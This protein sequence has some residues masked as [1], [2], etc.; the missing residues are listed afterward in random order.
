VRRFFAQGGLDAAGEE[1][2]LRS[3]ENVRASHSEE[4]AGILLVSSRDQVL[5]NDLRRI[6]RDPLTV[7]PWYLRA[8]ENPGRVAL[9]PKPIGR[10]V[11]GDPALSADDV[12]SVVKAVD[13][14]QG[15]PAGAILIDLKLKAVEGVFHGTS[16]G[17][18]GFFFITDR[19]GGIVYA[20]VNKVIYRIPAGWLQEGDGAGVRRVLGSRYQILSRDSIYTGWRTVGVFSINELLKEIDFLRFISILIAAVTMAIAVMVALFLAS[21]IARPVVELRSLM[22]RVEGGDLSV[23][24]TPERYDEVGQLGRSFNVMI[25]EIRNLIGQVYEEQRKKREAEL[26]ALH[27][28]IK[29]HF[30][31]NTLDTVKWMA[32]ERGADDVADMVEAITRIFR[33]GLSR[34]RE[35]ITLADEIEHVRN[36]LYIEKVRYEDKFDYRVEYDETLAQLYVIKLILQPLAEN[37]IYHG[38]KQRRGKGFISVDARMENGLLVMRVEDDGVGMSPER[39]EELERILSSRDL[40]ESGFGLYSVNERIRLTYGPEYGLRMSAREGG[41]TVATIRCPCTGKGA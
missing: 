23:S 34:G 40:A 26:R 2:I 9:Y 32:Q 18:N 20:P 11:R 37:S 33:I 13:A 29:P 30:F 4:I 12:V 38:I 39:L 1:Q 35:M 21:S 15:R 36:Y 25:E 6:T 3:L 7:E 8:V 27:E 17:R 22:K 19:E 31:Y 41:G 5:S 28:Q 14:G 16:L 10:N 24:C